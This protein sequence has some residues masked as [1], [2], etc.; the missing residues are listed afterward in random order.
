M[1]TLCLAGILLFSFVM[2]AGSA[3]AT[4]YTVTFDVNGGKV[5]AGTFSQRSV[6]AGK[7]L[8]KVPLN[9]TRSG[10]T[11][12]AWYTTKN[13]TGGSKVTEKYIPKKDLIAYARWTPRQ[14]SITYFDNTKQ[15]LKS[16]RTFDTSIPVGHAPAKAGKR[17]TGWFTAHTGGTQVKK[18]P[19]KNMKVYAR[20]ENIR[21]TVNYYDH[22]GILI[23]TTTPLYNAAVIAGPART[24]YSFTGWFTAKT[25]GTKIEKITVNRNLH[26]RYSPKNY[27][28]NYYNGTKLLKTSLEKYD[29]KLA[30]PAVTAPTGKKLDGWYTAQTGGVKKTIVDG[31]RTLYA[32]FV[33]RTYMVD[34]YVHD[35]ILNRDYLYRHV[36][37]EHG[38]PIITGIPVKVGQVFTG[39]S[40]S[41]SGPKVITVT[42]DMTLRARFEPA[43]Y[44][45]TYY[46]GATHIRT[47]TTAHGATTLAAPAK[48]GHT[49]VGWFTAPNGG[50]HVT[51]ITSNITLYARY[52]DS[53]SLRTVSFYDPTDPYDVIHLGDE[54][55][56]QGAVLDPPPAPKPGFVFEGWFT[57]QTPLVLVD[58]VIC[59]Q[60]DYETS[61]AQDMMHHHDIQKHSGYYTKSYPMHIGAPSVKK[62]VVDSNLVLYAKYRPL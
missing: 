25:G 50:M 44:T 51:A 57:Q 13:A 16:T 24:G 17:F 18:M 6:V 28:I 58:H 30:P 43:T 33:P 4:K 5:A 40:T 10:H 1:Y 2:E 60:C 26:A 42:S 56:A 20:Y 47:S 21:Y 11:F 49:F 37:H 23:R 27:T 39:W 7:A 46:D 12:V 53:T 41:V 32:R 9:P 31:N 45:V 38:S 19:A 55:I 29:A 8:G 48:S 15:I 54:M 3:A 52:N 36:K 14:Y 61:S 34:Y 22:T 59:G 35:D 62:T